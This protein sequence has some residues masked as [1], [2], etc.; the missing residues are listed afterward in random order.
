MKLSNAAKLEDEMRNR[1]NPVVQVEKLMSG[2]DKF[3]RSVVSRQ[4][5]KDRKQVAKKYESESS[6]TAASRRVAG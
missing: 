3:Y 2:F 1:S 4:L 6:M 5:R